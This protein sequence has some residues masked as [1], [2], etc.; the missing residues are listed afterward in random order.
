MSPVANL[1]TSTRSRELARLKPSSVQVALLAVNPAGGSV[2]ANGTSSHSM[3]AAAAD[4]LGASQAMLAADLGLRLAA[5]LLVGLR[6]QTGQRP[7]LAAL[8]EGDEH[9]VG[10][11]GVGA[12]AAHQVL[13]L[14]PDA[15]LQRGAA[16]VVDRGVHEHDVA[17]V[18][19]VQEAHLVE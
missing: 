2:P 10:G 5:A 14:D 11:G 1:P 19:R 7:G 6:G 17:D 15:D 8:V 18:H 3:A 13:G 9:Q 4:R 16:D 12:A